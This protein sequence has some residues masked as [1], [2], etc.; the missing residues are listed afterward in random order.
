MYDHN[1]KMMI[2]M[3]YKEKCLEFQLSFKAVFKDEKKIWRKRFWNAAVHTNQKKETCGKNNVERA[4][5]L[6][7][8][9]YP[10]T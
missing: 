2:K 7:N 4:D 8:R 6:T 10:Q 9:P 5:C 3:S 1:R